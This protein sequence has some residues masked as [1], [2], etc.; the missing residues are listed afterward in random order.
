MKL[1]ES[2]YIIEQGYLN[3]HVK[4]DVDQRRWNEVGLEYKD[5][6]SAVEALKIRREVE[7]KKGE[8][9]MAGILQMA[10]FRLKM[11]KTETQV[12]TF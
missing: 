6:S 2:H 11:V 4:E 1:I 9:Y 7:E 3:A 8:T 12:L 10:E 5:R